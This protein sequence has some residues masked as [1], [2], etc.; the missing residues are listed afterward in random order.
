M[1]TTTTANFIYLGNFAEMDTDESD[2]DSENPNVVLG[3]HTDL[4][5]LSITEVDADDDGVIMDDEGG[6]GDYISFDTGSGVVNSSLDTTA[7]Y[8]ANIELGDGS[9]VSQQVILVQTVSG[10]TFVSDLP[11]NSL[12]NISIQSITLTSQQNSNYSGYSANSTSVDN[13][14]V[15]CFCAGTS[16]ATPDGEVLVETLNPGDFVSTLDHGTQEITWV[17]SDAVNYPGHNAPINMPA[18]SLG[19]D[20]PTRPLSISPQHRVLLKS[21]IAFG[22]EEVLVPAKAL[23]DIN[24]IEQALRFIPT[25]YYHF[26]CNNHEIVFANGVEVETFFPGRQALKALPAQALASLL[27]TNPKLNPARPFAQ[28]KKARRLIERHAKALCAA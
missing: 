21:R 3:T 26:A 15:V 17:N 19:K 24:D 28:G 16:I 14:Q 6:S 20:I 22:F 25:T 1:T 23:L 27:A 9:I 18:G 12:D 4:S 13:S 2:W 11:P 5:I 8:N 10:D 7:I